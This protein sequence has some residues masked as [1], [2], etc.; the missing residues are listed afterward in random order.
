MNLSLLTRLIVSGCLL[1]A[2]WST[3][4]GQ[5]SS[6]GASTPQAGTVRGIVV[7]KVTGE[8]LENAH[9]AIQGT[10][11]FAITGRGGAYTIYHV[12]A[13]HQTLTTY[14]TGYNTA[15]QSIQVQPGGEV[16]AEVRL[17]SGL[18]S[19]DVVELEA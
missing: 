1:A 15:V 8:A 7:D 6:A 2:A 12:P 18:V 14:Y 13:G 9:V 17:A 4:F 5:S 19:S 10:S 3:S 16:T 11:R